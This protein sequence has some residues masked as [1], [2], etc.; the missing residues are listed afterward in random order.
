MTSNP[1]AT[2]SDDEALA[3]V[4]DLPQFDEHKEVEWDDDFE[5]QPRRIY[6]WDLIADQLRQR[7]GKW[8][9]IPGS[10]GRPLHQQAI[11]DRALGCPA[12]LR[13]GRWQVTSR[14]GATWIRYLGEDHEAAQPRTRRS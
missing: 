7:P 12:A 11:N 14:R 1:L 8:A 5:L 4:P 3:P 10:E 6:R 2:P 13:Q 9:K